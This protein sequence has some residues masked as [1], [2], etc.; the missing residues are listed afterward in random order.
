MKKTK[1]RRNRR[2]KQTRRRKIRGGVGRAF[3]SDDGNSYKVYIN[4]PYGK[5]E[6]DKTPYMLFQKIDKTDYWKCDWGDV[7][8]LFNRVGQTKTEVNNYMFNL[9][10]DPSEKDNKLS[11]LEEYMSYNDAVGAFGEINKSSGKTSVSGFVLNEH[12]KDKFCVLT[13]EQINGGPKVN[14]I[15]IKEGLVDQL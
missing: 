14:G 2:R 9:D 15:K 4:N 3:L 11:I 8:E 6:K 13:T 1:T 12:A 10:K 5:Y 7:V